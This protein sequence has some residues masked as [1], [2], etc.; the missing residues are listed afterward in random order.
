MGN[1]YIG[2]QPLMNDDAYNTS[3]AQ[4]HATID[5]AVSGIEPNLKGTLVDQPHEAL[6]NPE[7]LS[8]LA[9]IPAD[10]VLLNEMLVDADLKWQIHNCKLIEQTVTQEATLPFLYHYDTLADELKASHPLTPKLLARFNEPMTVATATELLGL[11]VGAIA[12]PWQ[13]KIIGTLVMFSESLQVAVRL[14]FTNSAK[15]LE[16][17]YT[18]DKADAL[19]QAMQS[20]HFFGD[21]FV[22]NRGSKPLAIASLH[23]TDQD[24]EIMLLPKSEQYQFVPPVYAVALLTE[25]D[26]HKDRLPQLDEAVQLRIK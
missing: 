5:P 13:V 8:A 7:A 15:A 2:N 18:T 22:L 12:T 23:A 20:W 6:I 16:P 14:R 11:P 26:T 21:V 4:S 19:T 17:I 1:F 9:A 3:P 10:A 25:L 24:N